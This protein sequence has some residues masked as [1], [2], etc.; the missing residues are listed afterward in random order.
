MVGSPH[1]ETG[2]IPTLCWACMCSCPGPRAHSWPMTDHLSG[3][4]QPILP[5][6]RTQYPHQPACL[7]HCLVAPGPAHS[8]AFPGSLTS[9]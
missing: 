8:L 4:R 1:V 9:P 3:R 5:W 6:L 7:V 2:I